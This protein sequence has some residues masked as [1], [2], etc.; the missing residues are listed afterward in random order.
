MADARSS[1]RQQC[2]QCLRAT[3][4]SGGLAKKVPA[5]THLRDYYRYTL[6]L[7]NKPDGSAAPAQIRRY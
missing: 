5:R 3:R 1:D 4:K 6:Q 2:T 7:C